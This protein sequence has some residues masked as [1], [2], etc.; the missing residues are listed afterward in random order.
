MK[1]YFHW[2]IGCAL[3]FIVS[4]VSASRPASAIDLQEYQRLRG[5][6]VMQTYVAGVGAGYF[7]SNA[8]LGTIKSARPLYCQNAGLSLNSAN[9]INILESR[10][11]ALE[12]QGRK[13]PNT[14]I[15]IVLLDG[16]LEAFPCK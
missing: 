1:R 3:S 7:W 16:L 14:P 15:E 8:Y 6:K 4:A 9:Y 10:I 2:S 12:K 5:D 11:K 13:E